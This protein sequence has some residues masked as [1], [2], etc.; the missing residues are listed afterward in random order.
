MLKTLGIN[1]SRTDRHIL[2]LTSQCV[3]LMST[4]VCLKSI[5]SKINELKEKDFFITFCFICLI[6]KALLSWKKSEDDPE[7]NLFYIYCPF[8]LSYTCCI[9]Y[10]RCY[11]TSLLLGTFEN[12]SL[13]DNFKQFGSRFKTFS[14]ETRVKTMKFSFLRRKEFQNLEITMYTIALLNFIREN[15]KWRFVILSEE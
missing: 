1:S 8:S 10:N 11:M 7:D 12:P 9:L 6:L 5:L 15:G 4:Y 2:Q 13:V 14:D 3:N